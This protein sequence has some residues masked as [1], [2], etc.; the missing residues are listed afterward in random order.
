MPLRSLSCADKE[1]E[2][3]LAQHVF[4]RL[5]ASMLLEVWVFVVYAWFLGSHKLFLATNNACS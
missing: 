1:E 2:A 3:I 4:D 5:L